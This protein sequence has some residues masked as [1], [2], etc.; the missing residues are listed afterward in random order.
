LIRTDEEEL[1]AVQAD[2]VQEQTSLFADLLGEP[3]ATASTAVPQELENEVTATAIVKQLSVRLCPS[4]VFCFT[5][6]ILF[7]HV[8]SDLHAHKYELHATE[9]CTFH[10]C[11]I[12]VQ[13]ILDDPTMQ[14]ALISAHARAVKQLSSASGLHLLH[15]TTWSEIL[16]SPDTYTHAVADSLSEAA[17]QLLDACGG[18]T[19]AQVDVASTGGIV[20]QLLKSI[21]AQSFQSSQAG[22]RDAMDVAAPCL[23][24]KALA[25]APITRLLEHVERLLERFPEQPILEQFQTICARIL[26]VPS[27]S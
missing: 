24:E 8:G 27:V 9:C 23:E 25:V 11:C 6:L 2:A 17:L 22:Q 1:A 16:H 7:V 21:S 18:C 26:G 19:A 12:S 14:S 10:N 20:R 4:P 5:L 15:S 3:S 13:D